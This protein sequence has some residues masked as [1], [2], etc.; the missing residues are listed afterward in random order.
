MFLSTEPHSGYT[1]HSPESNIVQRLALF[2]FLMNS[3]RTVF[4]LQNREIL[5]APGKSCF[6][7]KSAF[8]Q[9]TKTNKQ[10]TPHPDSQSLELFHYAFCLSPFRVKLWWLERNICSWRQIFSWK[11]S[12]AFMKCWLAQKL[13]VEACETD[14]SSS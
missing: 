12:L 10:E 9:T 13:F 14:S 1:S 3:W 8:K 4:D 7:Y 6:V 11:H 2:L 5:S